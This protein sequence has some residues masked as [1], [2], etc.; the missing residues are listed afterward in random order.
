MHL[1]KNKTY[2]MKTFLFD[3]VPFGQ[4]INFYILQ[5]VEL[6]YDFFEQLQDIALLINF[7]TKTFLLTKSSRNCKYYPPINVIL[8][9]TNE[10]ENIYNLLNHISLVFKYYVY[11]SRENNI[12]NIDILIDNLVRNWTDFI[13]QIQKNCK[14]FCIS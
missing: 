9:L 11:R 8:G 10:T 3:K 4:Q 6:C 5:N 13:Q 7:L 12:L 14:I 2:Q 1:T